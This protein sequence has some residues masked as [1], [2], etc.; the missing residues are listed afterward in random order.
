MANTTNNK[1]M[2]CVVIVAAALLITFLWVLKWLG[3]AILITAILWYVVYTL[4]PVG[5]VKGKQSDL[6][7]NDRVCP[8]CGAP[9]LKDGTCEYCGRGKK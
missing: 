2:G 8:S 9:L 7:T 1:G 3:L 5:G 6:T 4:H